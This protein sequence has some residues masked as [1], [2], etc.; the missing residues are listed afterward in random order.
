MNDELMCTVIIVTMLMS[1][2]LSTILAIAKE[3][4]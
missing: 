2:I 3:K 4:R 1:F